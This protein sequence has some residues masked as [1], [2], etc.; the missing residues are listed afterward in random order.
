[1]SLDVVFTGRAEANLDKLIAYL[2]SNW[3]AKTKVDF[4]AKLSE[5]LYLISK[6]PYLYPAS[7]L[8]KEL[9]RC[10]VNKYVAVY[11]R[12]EETRIVVITIQDTRINPESLKL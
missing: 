3:P 1:M 12:V 10:L 8:K 9:R 2:E 4:L 5:Q 11:Y 7:G 6:M